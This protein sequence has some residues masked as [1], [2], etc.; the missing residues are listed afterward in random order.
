MPTWAPAS[1]L[2]T[3]K[4]PGWRRIAASFFSATF[5]N[6]SMVSA[7][8]LDSLLLLA[9][10]LAVGRT[11]A[12]AVPSATQASFRGAAQNFRTRPVQNH[13]RNAPIFAQAG[14]A[15]PD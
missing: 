1:M 6:P 12:N 10:S 15:A 7:Y 2:E 9:Q 8:I 5:V 4:P 14:S 3:R 11:L 13:G